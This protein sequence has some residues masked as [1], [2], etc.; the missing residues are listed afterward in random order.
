MS[1]EATGYIVLHSN[2]RIDRHEEDGVLVGTIEFTVVRGPTI[3]SS[4]DQWILT[5]EHAAPE[6]ITISEDG[7]TMSLSE[8]A[9]DGLGRGYVRSR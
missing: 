4:E 1:D 8:N 2:N 9:Y 7:Q 5:Y 3:F 6:V